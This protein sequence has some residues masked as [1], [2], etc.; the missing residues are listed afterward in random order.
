M[1]PVFLVAHIPYISTVIRQPIGLPY[2]LGGQF[3]TSFADLKPL[4]IDLATTGRHIKKPAS[5]RAGVQATMFV[6]EFFKTTF[7]TLLTDIFP[8]FHGH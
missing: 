5:D 7:A 1:V 8:L 3:D 4:M 6:C 2:D